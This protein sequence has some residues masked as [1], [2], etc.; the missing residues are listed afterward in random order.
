MAYIDNASCHSCSK[1]TSKIERY[2]ARD[3]FKELR[4]HHGIKGKKRKRPPASGLPMTVEINGQKVEYMVPAAQ[5]PSILTLPF[6]CAP[7]ILRGDAPS[8]QWPKATLDRWIFKRH[9]AG[10]TELVRAM[11]GT[12]V[13]IRKAFTPDNFFRL[14]AKIAHCYAVAVWG[15]GTFKPYLTGVI[16]GS[17]PTAARIRTSRALGRDAAVKTYGLSNRR[18]TPLPISTARL[19]RLHSTVCSANSVAMPC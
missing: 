16:L 3:V 6:V 9:I 13:T 1:I 2:C 14:I 10:A 19:G 8:A 4:I 7:G 12:S 15:Y 18:P 17:E 5:H 11:G